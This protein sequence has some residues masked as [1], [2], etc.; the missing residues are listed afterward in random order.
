MNELSETFRGWISQET[1]SGAIP[2]WDG[3]YHAT[4]ALEKAKAFISF[5]PYKDGCEVVELR[6]QRSPEATPAFLTHFVLDD[7]WH[8]RELYHEMARTLEEENRRGAE[9]VWV[10]V[11]NDATITEI[12]R[13]FVEGLREVARMTSIAYEFTLSHIEEIPRGKDI[14]AIMLAPDASHLHTQVH[15]DYPHA[16]TVPLTRSVY[17]DKRAKKAMRLLLETIG[18]VDTLGSPSCIVAP[19]HVPRL[20]KT[21]LVLN[22]MYIDRCA[23]VDYRVFHGMESVVRGQMSK[24]LLSQQDLDDLVKTLFL[25]GVGIEDLDAV[26]LLV[27]GVVNY[28]SMN[29]PSLGDR[30]FNIAET[31]EKRYGIPVYVDN[32]TNAAAMGCYLLQDEHESLTLYRHQLGHMNGGQG[33]VI[34]GRVVFGRYG[35]AG[36][37]KFYQRRFKYKGHYAEKVW[38]SAGLAEICRNVLLASVGTISPDVAYVSVN[39]LDD[40][41][42]VRKALERALPKYCIPEV[43]AIDDYRERMFLGAA[44][45]SLERLADAENVKRG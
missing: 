2:A 28:C 16:V 13:R 29:L 41:E 33:T 8:A 26:A 32:N 45:L 39:A 23:L 17:T 10:C 19:K 4:V 38:T 44:A 14:L 9:M 11:P 42:D 30:D 5:L 43:V 24:A 36:E 21:V 1:I 6:I 3:R 37:P 27:P 40:L 18:E 22:I 15:E 34:G 31:L 25:Y 35:M 12:D 20:Q 7:R